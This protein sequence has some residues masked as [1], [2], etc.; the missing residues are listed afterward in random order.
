MDQGGRM[1][2]KWI[3]IAAMLTVAGAIAIA[4]IIAMARDVE[5]DKRDMGGVNR[6]KSKRIDLFRQKD[7]ED[8]AA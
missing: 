4:M 2:G 3:L 7:S 1:S 5:A 8:D 6:G